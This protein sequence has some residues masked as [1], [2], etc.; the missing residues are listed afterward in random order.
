MDTQNPA[1]YVMPTHVNIP[2][3]IVFPLF[4]FSFAVTLRQAAI[5]VLGGIGASEVYQDN[6]TLPGI[7]GLL[8][9]L[10][11]PALIVCLLPVLA[12]MTIAKRPLETWI[13]VLYLYW[14]QPRVYLWH[15]LS[16]HERALER[17]TADELHQRKY[18]SVPDTLINEEEA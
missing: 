17:L 2:D 14:I 11:M 15:R 6:A 7:S 1:R 16:V 8:L 18:A 12:F 13:I 10:V 9:H 4:G 3:T 5:L